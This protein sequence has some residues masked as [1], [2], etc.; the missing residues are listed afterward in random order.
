MATVPLPAAIG[1]SYKVTNAGSISNSGFEFNISWRDRVGVVGYNVSFN[2]STI[3]NRVLSLGNNDQA[4]SHTF[5]R[6][7]VGHP[8]GS[9]FGYVQDGIFQTQ[10][11]VEAYYP[12]AWVSQP[13]DIKF[14]DVNGDGK[15]DDKDRTFI[16]SP[17]PT[18]VYGF[19]LGLDYKN[20]DLNMT[21]N[22][23][24]GNK[25]LN[26]KKLPTFAQFNY[27]EDA[28]D[29]WHGAGTSNTEPMIN[30]SRGHN[31]V[32]S[33]NLLEN[34]SYLRLRGVQLGY[35]IPKT[36]LQKIQIN[37]LRV[38]LNAENLLTFKKNSGYTPEV[39][40]GI[41][42]GGVD[43]GNTYPLPMTFTGGIVLSF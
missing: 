23:I 35:T 28:I 41:L 3:R 20:F 27:Y 8:V 1:P 37:S 25:I 9:Y 22:G 30:A 39:G 10:E 18:F 19:S 15:I 43:E 16:G 29:R 6:T 24:H 5:H 17:I 42:E 7:A 11:E 14:K 36:L 38:Y 34:G 2:G 4:L 13:G 12:S 40:G 31:H 26:K 33:T 21:F 32:S